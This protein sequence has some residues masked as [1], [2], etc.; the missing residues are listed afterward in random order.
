MKNVIFTTL[1]I[2]LFSCNVFSQCT[3]TF[4]PY[5][6]YDDGWDGASVDIL[7][8]G[9]IKINDYALASGASGTGFTFS[10]P[11]GSVIS[12]EWSSGSYDGE[13]SWALDNGSGGAMSSGYFGMSNGGFG[14]NSA[15]DVITLNDFA[16]STGS[17]TNGSGGGSLFTFGEYTTPSSGTGPYIINSSLGIGDASGG[18]GFYFT[19]ASNG[20][21]NLLHTMQ[22]T[23]EYIQ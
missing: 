3:H 19:E 6:Y 18:S 21:T 5:D 15:P 9:Q 2:G 13:I 4:T 8:D 10:A 20:N 16:S 14:C 23:L 22:A 7:V 1:I 12:F 11:S 17:F